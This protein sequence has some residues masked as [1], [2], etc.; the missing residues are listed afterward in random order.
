[1]SEPEFDG[2][3]PVFPVSDVAAALT[4]YRD[5][6]GFE[7]GWTSGDPPTYANV[8]RGRI[9]ITLTFGTETARREAYVYIRGVDGYFAE[10]RG[11]NVDCGD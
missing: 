10:L 8:C 9:D 2:I 5:R 4:F 1:M 11:R 3:S 6:L 7:I